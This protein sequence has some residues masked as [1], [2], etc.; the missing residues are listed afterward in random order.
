M[1]VLLLFLLAVIAMPC[2]LTAQKIELVKDIN[3][4]PLS[5]F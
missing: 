5:A 1:K 4:T 2:K 3:K